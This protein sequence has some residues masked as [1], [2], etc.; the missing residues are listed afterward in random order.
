MSKLSDECERIYLKF[1]Q[2]GVY[3]YVRQYYPKTK[4]AWCPACEWQSPRDTDYACLVCATP[5]V[6][7][8]NQ[9]ES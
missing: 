5:T 2:E 1:G 3:D 4:W 7:Y 9:D 8:T 6:P